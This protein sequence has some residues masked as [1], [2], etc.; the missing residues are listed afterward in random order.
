MAQVDEAMLKV[1]D[2]FERSKKTLDQLGRE[3]GYSDSVARKAVWQFMKTSDPRL[4]TLRKF[5][6]AM[7]IS[8]TDLLSDK[9]KR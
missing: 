4:S 6:A 8:L 2:L 7:G 9:K 1:R 3:M 5:C